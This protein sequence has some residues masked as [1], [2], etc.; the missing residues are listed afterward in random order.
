MIDKPGPPYASL[1]NYPLIRAKK[2]TL[3]TKPPSM[4]QVFANYVRKIHAVPQEPD[5]W[6]DLGVDSV[7]YELQT[8][9]YKATIFLFDDGSEWCK[10]EV[11]A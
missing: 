4:A 11:I 8:G 10:G 9:H 5:K 3:Y 1:H 7:T 2:F 6:K